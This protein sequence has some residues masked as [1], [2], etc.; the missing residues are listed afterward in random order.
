MP[1]RPP[2]IVIG[3]AAPVILI[4]LL[5]AAWAIDSSAGNATVSRNV[6]IAGKDIGKL[7]EEK[8]VAVVK[9]LS[10]D[11][12]K[13]KVRI[14]TS[15][16]TYESTAAD[17]GLEIDQEATVADALDVGK[18]DALPVKPFFWLAS[19]VSAR[20]ADVKYNVREDA[21]RMQLALLEGDD[22]VQPAEPAIVASADVVNVRAG[23]PGSALDPK[24]VAKRLVE[25]AEKGENPIR[26]SGRPVEQKP[27]VDPDQAQE[28]AE[29][30]T[31]KTAAGLTVNLVEKAADGSAVNLGKSGQLPA[32]TVRSWLSSTVEN[33]QMVPVI[34]VEKVKADVTTALGPL[35]AEKKNASFDVVNGGVRINPSASGITCCDDSTGERILDAITDDDEAAPAD[36]V[37]LADQPD[38]TTADA[39]ALAIKEPIGVTTEWA[40]RPQV[41]SFTTY[42]A[43]CEPRVTNI[44]RMADIVRGSLIKPGE[45]FSL[46]DRVG[47]RTTANGFVEA[48]AI[49]DGVHVEEVGGGVSQFSTTLFNAAFFAGLDLMSHQAH[50]EHFARYPRGREATLGFPNPD[51]RIRN[52][53]PH[54]MLIWTSYTDT[55]ITVTIY[56]TPWMQNVT[57]SAPV[58]T[59]VGPCTKAT[60]TRTRQYPD[61]KTKSE[62]YHATYRPA[63]GI[64]C[65]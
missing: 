19:F 12:S 45:T 1:R 13:T 7:R 34:D 49:A 51:N 56:S 35:S 53:S 54:G 16:A 10:D 61:G 52:N 26:I 65:P 2:K 28:L 55:S 39:E 17:L 43:C 6:E 63:E 21:L 48:G 29:E 4:V 44:H 46:N 50:S 27:K 42:H 58:D 38:F 47:K 60:V 20:K 22:A 36:L 62:D 23:T 30:L 5:L 41:K 18:D 15:K 59:P 8:V 31:S 64:K 33:D 24:T 32:A 25:D 40:G 57:A 11:F 14:E 3:I 37:V 9:D